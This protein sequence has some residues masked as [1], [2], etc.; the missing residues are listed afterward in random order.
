MRQELGTFCYIL[1]GLFGYACPYVRKLKGIVDW[2][3]S[4]RD[5][6]ERAIS[7]SHQVT[8]LLDYVSRLLSEYLNSCVQASFTGNLTHP[9]SLT[10]VS[11][12][13]LRS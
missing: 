2:A 1:T 4:N 12:L 3:V 10:P 7:N 11:F 6:F 5:A 13:H 9:G 8:A